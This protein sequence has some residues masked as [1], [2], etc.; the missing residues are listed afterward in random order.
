MA[1]TSCMR[2]RAPFEPIDPKICLS[3]L[4]ADVIDSGANFFE[5]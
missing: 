5:N 2:R 1:T 3:G 4:V